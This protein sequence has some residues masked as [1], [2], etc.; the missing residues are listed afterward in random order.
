[1]LLALL[2]ASTTALA[3]GSAAPDTAS[4]PT[5]SP[6]S[7][8]TSGDAAVAV[9]DAWVRAADDGMTG[10]FGVVSND[11]D[12]DLTL[13]SAYSPAAGATELHEV[14]SSAGQMVMQP[15]EGG[16]D[17]PAGGTQVLEPGADHLMLMGLVAPLLPGDDVAITLTFDDGS[18]YEYTAQVRAAEV[19]DEAYAPTPAP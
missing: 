6:T 5:P 9:S 3:C 17:L 15:V 2:A 11:G 7:R 12:T 18:T 4:G 19:G 1:M 16:F 8:S 14:V 10:A 13:V